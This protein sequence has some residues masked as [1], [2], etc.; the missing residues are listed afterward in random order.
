MVKKTTNF[1]NNIDRYIKFSDEEIK[2]IREFKLVL[3]EGL[4]I[5][6]Y[7]NLSKN[8]EVK[9]LIINLNQFN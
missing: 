3:L 2:F 8:I 4:K 9:D 5:K 7:C 1:G 6:K